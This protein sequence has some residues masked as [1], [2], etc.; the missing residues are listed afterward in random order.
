MSNKKV[1]KIKEVEQVK[2]FAGSLLLKSEP[3]EFTPDQWFDSL[4]L[5]KENRPVFVLRP[6]N[7]RHR[8]WILQEEQRVSSEFLSWA[9]ITGFDLSILAKN[10]NLTPE[11]TEKKIVM[12]TKLS[13]LSNV[14]KKQDMI[15]SCIIGIK[16]GSTVLC[17]FKKA[18]TDD[19]LHP[20]IFN[21][22]PPELINL[23]DSKLTT[24]STLNL[25]QVTSL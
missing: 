6:F 25:K 9:R 7:T 15:R 22:F 3:V 18:E 1:V 12:L 16:F 10:E 4:G 11:D 13:E 5:P 2:S 20:D 17:D 24:I 8:H 23:I 14:E 21:Q 19:G